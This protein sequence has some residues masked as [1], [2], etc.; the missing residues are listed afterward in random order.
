MP[1]DLILS[2][3]IKEEYDGHMNIWAPNIYGI[4][5]I[6][7]ISRRTSLFTFCDNGSSKRHGNSNI[8]YAEPILNSSKFNI[9]SSDNSVAPWNLMNDCSLDQHS[10][11]KAIDVMKEKG[12]IEKFPYNCVTSFF[13]EECEC[14]YDDV[15]LFSCH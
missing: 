12:E 7:Q 9:L 11:K 8:N 1:R 10:E 3:R 14:Y 5:S 15:S 6:T 4:A 2:V 13:D